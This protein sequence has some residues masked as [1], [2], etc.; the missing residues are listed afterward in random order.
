LSVQAGNVELPRNRDAFAA[1][2]QVYDTQSNPLL[3]LEERYLGHLLPAIDGKDVLDAGCGTGRWLRRLADMGSPQSLH[4]IDSSAEMLAAVRCSYGKKTSLILAQL[5]VVPLLSDSVDLVLCSFVLSYV[6]DIDTLA[7]QLCRI[8][9]GKGDVMITD[10]HP[11]TARALGWKRSFRSSETHFHLQSEHRSIDE[12]R[13]AFTRQ[14]FQAVGLYQPSFGEP[15]Y[16]IFASCGKE[17]S[18]EDTAGRPAVYVLHLKPKSEDTCTRR[19]SLANTSVVLGSQ[20]MDRGSITVR[21]GLIASVVSDHTQHSVHDAIDLAGYTLFPG[22]INAHDHLEFG[23]FPRLGNPPYQNATDWARDIHES[24]RLLIEAHTSVPRDVR[25]WWGG[26]RNLLC[27]VTTVCHHNPDHSVLHDS[28]F[29]VHVITEFDWTHSLAFSSDLASIHRRSNSSRPFILHASEG[30]DTVARAEFTQL[31]DMNLLDSRAVLVHGLALNSDDLD[32][33]NRS[34]ASL[35]SCPSSNQFLFSQSPS[36]EQLTAVNRL[37]IG[38]DSSLTAEGDLLD[39]IRF[40]HSR[41]QLSPQ[42]LFDLVTLAPAKLLF[43]RNGAGRISPGAPADL[44]AVCSSPLSPARQLATISWRDI[45]LVIVGGSIRLASSQ[46]MQR[47]PAEI[48]RSLSPIS[49]GGV[50]RWIAAPVASL[51]ES[52]AQV[53]GGESVSLN[54]RHISL[55]KK[56]H[57]N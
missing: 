39:E 40:C 22:L 26:I 43:L 4:G 18:Y 16:P 7:R 51:L 46:M 57:V 54:G 9:R 38:S 53:L 14:G 28:R 31:L 25:L 6:S 15:E 44:F 12:V 52:A 21:D 37:A 34:G 47:L 33:L 45:E 55:P 11:D 3:A 29:P 36:R 5:P 41:L 35:I 13:Q 8:L 17:A 56:Q 27:G 42:K 23:L 10:M 49:V 48:G 24:F 19:I 30:I 1:W 32:K 2:A 50:T 20:E